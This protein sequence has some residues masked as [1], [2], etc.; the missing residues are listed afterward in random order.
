MKICL[1]NNLYGQFGR[2]GGSEQVTEIIAKGLSNHD[3]FTISTKPYSAQVADNGKDYY[4]NSLFP[5]LASL[6]IFLRLFWHL[7]NMFGWYRAG[8]IKKILKK[9]K[10]DLVI[11]N[12]L[13]GLSYLTPRVI[14]GLKIKHVH[15]L[16]D[17]QLMHPSGIM[18]LGEEG[19]INS[20]PAKIYTAKNK[21]CFKDVDLVIAPS[22]WILD[23]HLK[24][25]LFKNITTKH[26]LN[27]KDQ[28]IEFNNDQAL[29]KQDFFF[30][31]G[32][33]TEHK[34]IKLLL[35][36]FE[37]LNTGE[38]KFKLK[39]VGIGALETE[40]KAAVERCSEIEYLGKL[41]N[42]EVQKLMRQANC[43]II[44]AL[45]YENSPTVILE[46]MKNNLPTIG[47]DLGGIAELLQSKF[48]LFNPDKESLKERVLVAQKHRQELYQEFQKIKQ[49]IY[50]PTVSE[51]FAE[52]KKELW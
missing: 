35:D 33:L 16:H 15:V 47:S 9:I 8:Q 31:V 48:L 40:V 18:Y 44:P 52:I 51:Y 3:I 10:P 19:K 38:E 49:R 26:L 14:H 13:M 34:G 4:L 36:V 42:H 1:I 6:P 20:L 37:E 39:I 21:R 17:I 46:A 5:N 43:F 2:G 11:T 7:F 23:L 32:Q 30:S 12:N 22:K 29:I 41:P 28:S 45:V 50:Q 25:G 24:Q 27:P